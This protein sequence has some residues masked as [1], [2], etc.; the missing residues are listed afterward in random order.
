MT[1]S[2]MW[3]AWS[4]AQCQRVSPLVLENSESFTASV[5]P[6]WAHA[7]NVL[8]SKHP[9]P[10]LCTQQSDMDA[11][12]PS[13]TSGH[14]RPQP[15]KTHCESDTLPPAASSSG[16]SPFP[17]RMAFLHPRKTQ[18]RMSALAPLMRSI[19]SSCPDNGTPARSKIQLSMR[20]YPSEPKT[21]I[22]SP[23]RPKEGEVKIFPEIF[24]PDP[25]ISTPP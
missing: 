19:A 4:T 1:A 25:A 11:R 22:Q 21:W 13:C 16:Q 18:R 9:A 5:A 14:L 24:L 3:L 2:P 7:P 15:M 23:P 20:V 12:T 10:Q 17:A 8:T 6:R